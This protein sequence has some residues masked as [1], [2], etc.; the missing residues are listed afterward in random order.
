MSH[1]RR[2]NVTYEIFASSTSTAAAVATDVAAATVN[3]CP[4]PLLL[5]RAA[6]RRR[7]WSCCS[8]AAPVSGDAEAPP[9]PALAA[10]RCTRAHDGDSLARARVVMDAH[11]RSSFD[12]K[13]ATFWA[14][15]GS[16]STI[17]RLYAQLGMDCFY[18]DLIA[19]EA[20][21]SGCGS[22]SMDRLYRALLTEYRARTQ[23]PR[24]ALHDFPQQPSSGAPESDV[25]AFRALKLELS[26]TQLFAMPLAAA[27]TVGRITS[28]LNNAHQR[29]ERALQ[30]QIAELKAQLAAAELEARQSVARVGPLTPQ[31]QP[32][33]PQTQGRPASPATQQQPSACAVASSSPPATPARQISFS[34]EPLASPALG[35]SA[36]FSPPLGTSHTPPQQPPLP[37]APAVSSVSVI[38]LPQLMCIQLWVGGNRPQPPQAPLQAP[39]P[40][41]LSLPFFFQLHVSQRP[42]TAI[43]MSHQSSPGAVYELGM[44]YER[45][46]GL[47]SPQTERNVRP[48]R[49]GWYR[50]V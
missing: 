22:L 18:R 14:H 39:L 5:P 11:M 46:M 16:A 34:P 4:W 47:G 43:F 30:E 21:L 42:G 41:L 1:E 17:A 15:A 8:T 27:E 20:I 19:I 29:A 33:P 36:S 35:R 10:G 23:S 13:D 44:G 12:S 37:L 31:R 40:P 25:R 32:V 49:L 24:N 45:G 26:K 38:P 50:V 2:E 28:A 48:D 9:C 6:T 3:V 7:R